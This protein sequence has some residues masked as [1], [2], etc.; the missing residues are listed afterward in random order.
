MKIKKRPKAFMKLAEDEKNPKLDNFIKGRIEGFD[1]I[2]SKLNELLPLLRDAK[3]KILSFYNRNP[4]F[5]VLFSTEL[6]I[7]YIDDLIKLFR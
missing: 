3:Q 4:N 6:A 7:D 2:E 5:G 1:K